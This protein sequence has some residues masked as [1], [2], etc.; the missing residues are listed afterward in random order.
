MSHSSGRHKAHNVNTFDCLS[1][2]MREG[3]INNNEQTFANCL[4]VCASV[5]CWPNQAKSP[6][7]NLLPK[8]RL[9]RGSPIT[10]RQVMSMFALRS[11]LVCLHARSCI[12][13]LSL[14]LGK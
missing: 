4:P 7:L 10:G 2:H 14:F 3:N 11:F 13:S 12:L 8:L 6:L 5:L 9:I 1:Y